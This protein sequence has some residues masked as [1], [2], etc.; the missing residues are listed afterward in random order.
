MTSGS[1]RRE[2]GRIGLLYASLGAIIGSGWLFGPLNAAREAGSLSVGSWLIGAASILLLGL[3]FAE[4]GPLVPRSGSIIHMSHIGNGP[5]LGRVWSWILFFSYVSVP[6]VEVMAILTYANNYLPGFLHSGTGLLTSRGFVVAIFLLGMV[7]AFNFLVIRLVLL[8][9]SAAT[10][11]KLLIPFATIG[12]LLSRS[13]HP[14][15]L[16]VSG[17]HSNIEGMFAA[18][19]SAGV[20]FSFFGFRQAIDLAGETKAPG[21]NIP[22][23]VIGSVLVGS[24][25]YV[26][27]QVAFLLSVDPK[28]LQYGGWTDLHFPGV[29]GP[30]AALAVSVGAVWWGVVL[31]VDALISPAGTAF[32]Y[33]TSAARIAMATGE[34]GSAPRAL[35]QINGR[36]V[37]WAGLL[38][39][40]S[41]G[42]LFF[43]PFPSW[44]RLV[45]YISSVTVLSYCL[46]PIILLQ[47][48]R[49]LPDIPRPFRLWRANILAPFAFVVSNWIVFWSGLA[50]LTFTFSVLFL[51][52]ASY[53]AIRSLSMARS[54]R[55]MKS[56]GFG[57]SGLRHSWWIFPYFGGLWLLSDLGPKSLG[58]RGVIPFFTDMGI[59]AAGSLAVLRLA[60]RCTV[61]DR[62]IVRYMEELNEVPPAAP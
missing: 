61:P 35:S 44:H 54:G 11:W 2:G 17:L 56:P 10:W 31:Y 14:E 3:V 41:V 8:I 49:A 34:A 33:T 9:N 20:I 50:T 43:F 46:G 16:S 5:L 36:G 27:L 19:G 29:T 6:P 42:S 53:L 12:L 48:R 21:R 47:L 45:A 40:W 59:L 62:E 18:V 55:M 13:F 51:L 26:G 24:F 28:D 58:G 38:L 37:P 32:I 57:R 7:V 4:L 30:F 60:L 52:L 25:L 1:L 23:A 39:S 15:N 22:F